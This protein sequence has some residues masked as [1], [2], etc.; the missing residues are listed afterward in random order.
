MWL[1]FQNK[2]RVPSSS[3]ED[4]SSPFLV[5]VSGMEACT[6]PGGGKRCGGQHCPGLASLDGDRVQFW[7]L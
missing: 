3:L 2:E 1:P 4:E 6:A 7:D 5:T